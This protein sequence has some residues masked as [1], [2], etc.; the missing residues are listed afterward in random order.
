[1]RI[2]WKAKRLSAFFFVLD[3]SEEK[4]NSLVILPSNQYY[5]IFCCGFNPNLSKGE[6]KVAKQSAR[7]TVHR[8]SV[9]GQFVTKKFAQ[10]HPKTTETERVRVG[11]K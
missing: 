6:V 1:M 11:K 4:A 5:Y 3:R 9:S 7:K 10:K 2:I 8:N